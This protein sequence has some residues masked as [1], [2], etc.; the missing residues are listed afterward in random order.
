M[1]GY[2]L[3][4]IFITMH[5]VVPSLR[6]PIHPKFPSGKYHVLAIGLSGF[7]SH[8]AIFTLLFSTFS[9]GKFCVRHTYLD[10][11]IATLF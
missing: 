8:L 9:S 5:A 4:L 10:K 2:I 1:V 7:I 3:F 11:Q 6:S